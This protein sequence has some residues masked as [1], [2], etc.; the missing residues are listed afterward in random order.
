VRSPFAAHGGGLHGRQSG[1]LPGA[2]FDAQS[3]TVYQLGTQILLEVSADDF[4]AIPG[5]QV[6]IVVLPTAEA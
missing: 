6:Y 4:G 1:R 2:G 5:S 3:L